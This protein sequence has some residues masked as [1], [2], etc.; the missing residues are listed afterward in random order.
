MIFEARQM[1]TGRFV[2]FTW[3]PVTRTYALVKDGIW[4]DY[5]RLRIIKP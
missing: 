4:F 1:S 2:L 3:E 5:L